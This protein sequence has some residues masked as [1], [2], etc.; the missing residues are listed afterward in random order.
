MVLSSLPSD[1][2]IRVVDSAPAPRH[3][4]LTYLSYCDKALHKSTE[5]LWMQLYQE[6][7]GSSLGKGEDTNSNWRVAY[8]HAWEKAR[9]KLEQV[10]RCT[11]MEEAACSTSSSSSR[12]SQAPI[13]M[14][15]NTSRYV[16]SRLITQ[17]ANAVATLLTATEVSS[18]D[19]TEWMASKDGASDPL[20]QLAMISALHTYEKADIVSRLLRHACPHLAAVTLSLRYYTWS[21]LRDCRGFRARDDMHILGENLLLLALSPTHEIWRVFHRGPVNEIRQIGFCVTP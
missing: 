6:R 4:F 8:V 2:L 19:V 14:G 16:D 21:Q 11:P 15:M 10:S 20:R 7:F 18:R 13:S 9:N 3:S 12:P 5:P 17:S 1:V